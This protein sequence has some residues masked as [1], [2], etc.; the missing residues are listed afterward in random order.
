MVWQ[1][2]TE[3]GCGTAPPRSGTPNGLP[4]S[5]LVCR[6]DPPGNEP[7]GAALWCR[8]L[9]Q[10][11]LWVKEKVH[12]PPFQEGVGDTSGDGGGGDTS[13]DG[14]GGDTSGDGGGGDTSGDG[15]GNEN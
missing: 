8:Q 13:G 3:I 14:G 11:K 10:A 7:P 2:T 4:Y 9:H 6:Y 5:I 12:P 15:G 1:A